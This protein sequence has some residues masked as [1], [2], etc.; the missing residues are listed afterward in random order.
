MQ[1][2]VFPAPPDSRIYLDGVQCNSGETAIGDCTNSGIGVA[3]F[4]THSED[5]NIICEFYTY[6]HTSY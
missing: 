4:C 1:P 6:K 2:G 3:Q 5:V